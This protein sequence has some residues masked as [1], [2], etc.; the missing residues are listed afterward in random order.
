M[1]R[2]AAPLL[3]LLLVCLAGCGGGRPAGQDLLRADIG[4]TLYTA[5]SGPW[6][7]PGP[8]VGGAPPQWRE[9]PGVR[10]PGYLVQ[11]FRSLSLVEAEARR[12]SAEAVVRRKLEVEFRAP[13]YRV[14]VGDTRT[15][16]EAEA[17]SQEL[18]R[19]GFEAALVVEGLV[20]LR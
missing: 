18:V 2:A 7:P 10:V 17:L 19:L 3:P 11:I 16:A 9:V 14:L 1:R 15:R 12:R 5:T 20:D 4:D 6:E 13:Y 8:I